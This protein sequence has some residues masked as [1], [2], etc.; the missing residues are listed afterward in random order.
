[1]KTMKSKF[2]GV[3]RACGESIRRGEEIKW[4]RETGALHESCAQVAEEESEEYG[5]EDERAGFERG[6]LA[7]DRR[8]GRSGLTVMR[9]AGGATMT[10]NSRGRCIDAPCCGCCS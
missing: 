9:F 10:Q 6:T 4:S 8:Q 7:N 2:A 3:C 5:D 1:M